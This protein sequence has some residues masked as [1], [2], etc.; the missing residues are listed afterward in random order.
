MTQT[1]AQVRRHDCFRRPRFGLVNR[2]V[3]VAPLLSAP[4]ATRP[5]LRGEFRYF[6]YVM[7]GLQARNRC[8]RPMQYLFLN[9]SEVLSASMRPVTP[10]L[11]VSCND[12]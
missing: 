6:K 11:G 5:A 8:G 3:E 1:E 9:V 12:S 7:R 4:V 10:Q 2:Q